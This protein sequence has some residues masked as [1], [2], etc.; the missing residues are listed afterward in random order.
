[1]VNL[2]DNF[3]PSGLA[4]DQLN[5]NP[6]SFGLQKPDPSSLGKRSKRVVTKTPLKDAQQKKLADRHAKFVENA[7]A[8]PENVWV[9][10][11]KRSQ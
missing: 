2:I 7:E 1:M 4:F 9:A 3:M 11:S 8:A 10:P 6:M 5:T